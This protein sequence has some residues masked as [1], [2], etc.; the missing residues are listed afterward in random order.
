MRRRW[1]PSCRQADR[2]NVTALAALIPSKWGVSDANALAL[3]L[4]RLPVIVGA[5]RL[6]RAS[7]SWC[8][9]LLIAPDRVFNSALFLTEELLIPPALGSNPALFL[10]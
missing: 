3:S 5:T 2:P 6:G 8:C 4:H 9:A 1:P 10:S 7:L